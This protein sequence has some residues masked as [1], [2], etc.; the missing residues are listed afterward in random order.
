MKN[1]FV[2]ILTL[3]CCTKG[4]SQLR[5]PS[6]I[7]EVKQASHFKA[8]YRV[9]A[10]SMYRWLQQAQINIKYINQLKPILVLPD[11]VSLDSANLPPG[12]YVWVNSYLEW[13]VANWW[14]ES[15]NGISIAQAPKHNRL[16]V[17]AGNEQ[18]STAATVKFNDKRLAASEAWNGFRI[19]GKKWETAWLMVAS[20]QDTLLTKI[21]KQKQSDYYRRY[22][23]RIRNWPIIGSII[24]LPRSIPRWFDG[25]PS[26]KRRR[27]LEKKYGTEGFVL[28]NQPL[29]KP[30]DTVKLKAWLTDGREKPL[31][32]PQNLT[33]SY[34]K[35]N[36]FVSA[37]LGS[38]KPITPGSFLYTLPLPDSFPSDTRYSVNF[39]GKNKYAF[40]NSAFSIEDY[41]LPDISKFTWEANGEEF[42]AKDTLI[43]TA[44]ATDAS[45]LPLL[46]ASVEIFLLTDNVSDWEADT[47][48]VADTLYRKTLK[49]N[50][51]GPTTLSIPLAGLPKADLG[52]T[53]LAILKNSS[54]EVQERDIS[55]ELF[56]H[57]K[58]VSF[59]RAGD[60]LLI[61]WN[62]DDI[63]EPAKAIMTLENNNWQMDT[64]IQLPCTLP[65]HPLASYYSVAVLD[66][67]GRIVEEADYEASDDREKG[68]LPR[69]SPDFKRDSVGF[70]VSNPGKIRLFFTVYSGKKIL[71]EGFTNEAVFSWFTRATENRIYFLKYDWIHNGV[72]ESKTLQMGLPY[73][74]LQVQ[75]ETSPMVQPGTKDTLLV[76]VTDY[77]GRPVDDINLSAVAH[78]LQLNDRLQ[79]PALPLVHTYKNRKAPK[80]PNTVEEAAPSLKT[81]DALFPLSNIRQ[82]L[83]AD[84]MPWYKWLFAKEPLIIH[85]SI[86]KTPVAEIAVHAKREGIPEKLYTVYVNNIPVWS[87]LVNTRNFYS[88]AVM[89]GLAKVSIRTRNALITTDSVYIQPYYKHDIFFNLDSIHTLKNTRVVRMPDTL[90]RQETE[91]LSQ[92]FVKFENHADNRNALIWQGSRLHWLEGNYA[93][94]VAGPFEAYPNLQAWKENRYHTYF[95]ME[96]GYRYRVG[97]N[98]VRMEK[99]PLF[100]QNP[101]MLKEHGRWR[102][103]EEIPVMELPPV[104][105]PA[106]SKKT[107]LSVDYTPYG[108]GKGYATAQVAIRDDSLNF[109][110]VWIPVKN[111]AAFRVCPST[112]MVLHQLQP[113]NYRV[114]LIKEDGRT[115]DLGQVSL[116]LMGTN[117]FRWKN[118][119]FEKAKPLTDSL[120]A[121][122]KERNLPV[123][124]GQEINRLPPE[125]MWVPAGGSNLWGYVTDGQ[126]GLPVPGAAVTLKGTKTG[127]TTEANGF[128]R[129]SG[130]RGGEYTL[131]VSSV[132]YQWAEKTV[133]IRND[134]TLNTDFSLVISPQA[135]NEVVV[136]GYG[137]VRRKE[138]TGAVA[139][140]E[141]SAFNN[142]LEGKVA[143]VQVTAESGSDINI[144]GVNSFSGSQQPLFV[145]DG[146][147]M[148]SFPEG[149]D[150]TLGNVTV[151]VLQAAA[152][153]GI[154]GS[155]GANGVILIN[156]GRNA[157]PLLR[158][159]FSDYAYWQPNHFTGKDGTAKI[160]VQYPDNITNWQHAVY[161]AGPKGRYGRNLSTTKAFKA[162]QGQLSAPSFLIE[163]DSTFLVG[164]AM[165]YTDNPVWMETGFSLHG[166]QQNQTLQVEAMGAVSPAF[167]IMA[168]ASPDT[169]KPSFSVKDPKSRSDG[170]QR[171]IPVLPKGTV[172]KAGS[173]FLLGSKDTT[174][175]FVPTRTDVPVQVYATTKLLDLVERELQ[176]LAAYPY[177]CLEQTAN[178][179]WG[180][181][182]LK[183]ISQMKGQR[184]LY[185]KRFAPLLNKLLKNQ[186]PDG[187]WGW[188]P[189]GY[190]NLHI[191]TRILQV[192]RQAP[193]TD[194]TRK[195]IRD[196]YLFLQNRLPRLART[197]KIEALY[198]L[199][200][201]G[202]MYPYKMALDSIPFDSLNIHQQWQYY[203][204]LAGHS[205]TT[206]SLWQ[207]L[208]ASR[209]E[210]VT[211]AVYWG[212]QTW[213]WYEAPRATMVVAWRAIKADSSRQNLLPRLQ[214]YFLEHQQNGWGNTVEKAEISN[215]M[216]Q[217]AIR[218]KDFTLGETRL[219]VNQDSA[220]TKF[221]ASFTLPQHQ[222][223]SMQKTGFGLMYLTLYQ[224][225]QNKNP[226][227]VDSLFDL[228]TTFV[229]QGDTVHQ[230]VTGRSA[231]VQV[232]LLAKKSAQ[233]V[234]LEIPLPAGCVVTEKAQV[235]GQHREYLKDRTIIFIEYLPK[236]VQNF[237]IPLEVRY[238]G[239]YSLNPAKIELMYQPVFYGREAIKSI[240]IQ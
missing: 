153:V 79:L 163:G 223:I 8:V 16:L 31:K 110:Q 43:L 202:H 155:R 77:R 34:R 174:V 142:M 4:F 52:L 113:E 172:E 67:Q 175:S 104:S 23:K 171:S 36:T 152:A 9:P 10:D 228:T 136:I 221:P 144:R 215:L 145:V 25:E 107:I 112:S 98:L 212:K 167:G 49:M 179:L 39:T 91:Q 30:G 240:K 201:G 120:I 106:V 6:E 1:L 100:T 114:L 21:D 138:L 166:G 164:K 224:Q 68:L 26:P 148:E 3:A 159:N 238:K 237:H 63:P 73:K 55:F 46:D 14:Q 48:F 229:Q 11:S 5:Y 195:A 105:K 239:A 44:G 127:T 184:F 178:K 69:V 210:S 207:K 118:P 186:Q 147:P 95:P 189:G 141:S 35:Q 211:G 28:F 119:V 190:P 75:T 226:Q 78:N 197:E 88:H 15:K 59:L 170:E 18:P 45:G 123:S 128:Y 208:W 151:D 193:P 101:K 131:V 85:R 57:K 154:Y 103:G 116:Q 132:G 32:N 108:T 235:P 86:I 234:M 206:D 93:E 90:N 216:L 218:Q 143:G 213:L 129:I 161:A 225:W 134:E 220:L 182:M 41:K 58:E 38:I 177:D 187:G 27:K 29:Y 231:S 219:M 140:V 196:G 126:S 47:L 53:A 70:R 188:W 81:M 150:T 99:M 65:W 51:T 97:D 222:A 181:L 115:A 191:T 96:A 117:C 199:S 209:T 42:L 121:W 157:G 137:T 122:Q 125:A 24:R 162:I 146:V 56:Q 19:P 183:D 217:E 87:H 168:P 232:R 158:T 185:E 194:A 66:K 84:T 203:S 72:S 71:W 176:S 205:P 64:V 17:Y 192:L 180:L 50:T 233:F 92:L 169:L 198:A 130:F 54:N 61:S 200:Q 74:W 111:P 230:L 165:N 204:T 94:W 109:W 139:K 83:G 214:Q 37:D 156:T 33:L 13:A 173:F 149:L 236:G 40:F 89:P 227:K 82:T 22:K 133:R 12:Q 102:V 135:L 20:Y 160:P 60:S 2:T 76:K 7:R 124:T 80:A 62:A